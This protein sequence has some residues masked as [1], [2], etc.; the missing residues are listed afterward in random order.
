VNYFGVVTIGCLCCAACGQLAGDDDGGADASDASELDASGDALADASDAGD[1]GD[2]LV[3]VVESDVH[4][5]QAKC[6]DPSQC[7]ASAPVCCTTLTFD[8]DGDK[9]LLDSLNAAC[10]SDESCPTSFQP[11]CGG[12]EIVR[13]CNDQADCTEPA[14]PECCTFYFDTTFT[15]QP[16]GLRICTSQF[17]AES[18]DASCG[19]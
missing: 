9:C 13:Q 4:H 2:A 12:N 15:Q 11:F 8:T 18:A 14:A 5:I 17:A 1:G 6:A 19:P 16:T 10:G 3:D 7:D